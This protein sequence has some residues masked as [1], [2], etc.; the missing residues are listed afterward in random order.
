VGLPG[1]DSSISV[2]L[3]DALLAYRDLL[4]PPINK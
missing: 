2:A 3:R 4:Q 1:V